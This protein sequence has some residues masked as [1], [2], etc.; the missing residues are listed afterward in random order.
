LAD[1][2]GVKKNDYIVPSQSNGET[3]KKQHYTLCMK[4]DW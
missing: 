4:V 1:V 3:N 2:T